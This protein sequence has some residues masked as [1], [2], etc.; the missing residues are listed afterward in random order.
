MQFNEESFFREYLSQEQYAECLEEQKNSVQPR[1]IFIIAIERGYIND[2]NLT[3]VLKKVPQNSSGKK[4]K[5]PKQ[6]TFRRFGELCRENGFASAEQI[7]ECLKIQAGLKKEK[8]NFRLGQ[9]LIEKKYINTRQA[10]QVLEMQG[11]KI[12]R[13]PPCD[14]KYN[15]RNFK[16]GKRY[17]CPKCDSELVSSTPSNSM[18]VGVDRSFISRDPE[19]VDDESLSFINKQVGEYKIVAFLG[20]GGMADVYKVINPMRRRTRALKLMKA[21]AGFERFNKEFESSN[22]LRHPNIVRVYEI[23]KIESRPYFFME[24]VDGGSLDKRIEKMGI[25]SLSEGLQIL[26]QVTIALKYAHENNIIHRDIKPSNILISRKNNRDICAKITDFGI[27]KTSNDSQVTVTGHLV[28]TFKYMAPEN[29]KGCAADTRGDIF[30]LGIMSYEIFTGKEPFEV[31]DPVGYLFV[32]IKETPSPIHTINP[33]LP[34]ALSKIVEKMMCKDP[35]DRYDASSLLR[36]VNRLSKHLDKGESGRIIETEDTTSVFYEKRTLH[37]IK[38][39]IGRITQTF[40]RID[41]EELKR[42]ELN[43]VN[44]ETDNWFGGEDDGLDEFDPLLGQTEELGKDDVA[45]QQYELAKSLALKGEWE[46]AINNLKPIIQLYSGT[47]WAQK[48][49]RLVEKIE[50]RIKKDDEK[51]GPNSTQKKK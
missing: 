7:E 23:G 16:E 41:P 5:S 50:V 11:K 29:I 6:T 22:T 28:G 35:K 13:C 43:K 48:S 42:E 25:I 38:G 36:D 9:I 37:A 45:R 46:R 47:T 10:K 30:S 51:Y 33:D 19:E 1:S 27:A 8:K 4:S 44:D 49:R 40:Q 14:T 20:A 12:L 34:R 2:K 15:I 32:N 31:D 26:K 21:Q 39:I 24:Y 18:E 17:Q 3:E